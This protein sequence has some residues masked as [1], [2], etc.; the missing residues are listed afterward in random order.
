[1]DQNQS[2]DN[3]LQKAIDNINGSGTEPAPSDPVAAPSTVPEGDSGELGEPVG[4]FPMPPEPEAQVGIV[5]PGPE[6]IAPLD[7][8]SIPDLGTPGEATVTPA[9]SGQNT[10]DTPTPVIGGDNGGLNTTTS[11]EP[12]G[13]NQSSTTPD[14]NNSNDNNSAN[15]GTS[16]NSEQ[17]ATSPI[18]DGSDTH[19]I[20]EAALKALMPL[21]KDHVKAS[22]EEK[23][24]LCQNIYD[25]LHDSSVFEQAYQAATEITNED[26]RAKALLYI[27]ESIG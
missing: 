3:D 16:L 8:I 15:D 11:A 26:E 14:G 18:A 5:T 7:P 9:V 21:I 20:K 10:S 4:P 6:P 25:N 23:F 13:D 24:Q 1:M 17:T 2:V 19:Q 12:A 27:I 22:P